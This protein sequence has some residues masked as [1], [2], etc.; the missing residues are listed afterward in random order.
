MPPL[1]V[2]KDRHYDAFL[3]SVP[4]NLQ[5]IL[6]SNLRSLYIIL[7]LSTTKILYLLVGIALGEW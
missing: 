7:L 3:S 4:H 6:S 2:M 1:F 5:T